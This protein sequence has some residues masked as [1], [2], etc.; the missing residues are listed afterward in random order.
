MAGPTKA[1]LQKELKK[2]ND[3][4]N[5][6]RMNASSGRG[7][8]DRSHSPEGRP[9]RKPMASSGKLEAPLREGYQRYWAINKDGMMERLKA[10][11]WEQVMGD[12]GKPMVVAID[13]DTSH[14]LMEIP[15]AYYDEDM[16]AQQKERDAIMDS[17]TGA[18][19]SQYVPRGQERIAKDEV[20]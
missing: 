12:D 1:D 5:E 17:I 18:K 8:P 19:S 16:R 3:A 14:Y 2:A 15:Q 13:K 7:R 20:Y 9:A 6:L 4:I 11:Y 10:A